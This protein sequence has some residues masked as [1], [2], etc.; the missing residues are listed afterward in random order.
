MKI[1][2]T[3]IDNKNIERLIQSSTNIDPSNIGFVAYVN[4]VIAGFSML[5][6]ENKTAT[7]KVLNIY[8]EFRRRG[9]GK[10]MLSE[11]VRYSNSKNLN[12]FAKFKIQRHKTENIKKFYHSRG[13]ANSQLDETEYSVNI[14]NWHSAFNSEYGRSEYFSF[15]LYRELTE[16][17]IQDVAKIC[18]NNLEDKE[19]LQP[20]SYVEKSNNYSLYIVGQSGEVYG[21]CIAKISN[22]IL[23]VYCVYVLPEYRHLG[24]W[25]GLL[26]Y[27][28]GSYIKQRERKIHSINFRVGSDNNTMNKFVK[29]LLKEIDHIAINHYVLTLIK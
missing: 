26:H 9:I 5:Q 29:V 8:N 22:N 2:I 25:I 10:Q 1:T 23:H 6:V 4:N 21:W 24:I 19:Y 7:I 27:M 3:I 18:I 16:R 28:S 20:Y 14:E 15:K 17:E 11:I 13:Y 12:L